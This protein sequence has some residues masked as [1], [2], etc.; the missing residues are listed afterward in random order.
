MVNP[1]MPLITI[2]VSYCGVP[3]LSQVLDWVSYTGYLTSTFVIGR[4]YYPSFE[5][6]GTEAQSGFPKA[7]DGSK[8]LAFP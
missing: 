5:R 2:N 3:V 4:Y 8:W 1:H 6:E 7:T